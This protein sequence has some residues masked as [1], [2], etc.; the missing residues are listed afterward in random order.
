M[1][2]GDNIICKKTRGYFNLKNNTYKILNIKNDVNLIAVSVE[3]NNYHFCCY[4]SSIFN[5]KCFVFDEYFI[6][7]KEYRKLK[8]KK[9]NESR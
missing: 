5:E 8:L 3:K 7:L 1:K 6:S 9:I 4:Y 2:V